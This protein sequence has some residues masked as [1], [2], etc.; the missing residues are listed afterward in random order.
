[1]LAQLTAEHSERLAEMESR[2]KKQFRE[3]EVRRYSACVV[4][5][6]HVPA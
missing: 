3:L 1:M 2:Y 6:A 5:F 4:V